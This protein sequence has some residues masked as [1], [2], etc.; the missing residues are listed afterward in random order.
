LLA[1]EGAACAGARFAAV[2]VHKQSYR[3]TRRAREHR[4]RRLIMLAS[5]DPAAVALLRLA[6]AALAAAFLLRMFQ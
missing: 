2:R 3:I 4:G 1:S 6:A 5:F